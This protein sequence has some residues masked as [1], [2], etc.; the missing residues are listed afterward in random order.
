[1]QAHPDLDGWFFVGIWPL[2]AERGSMPLWEEAARNGMKTVAFDTLPVQ[3]GYLKDGLIY[4]L[5]GQKYW[6]WGL[7]PPK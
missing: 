4:A 3:L 6:G 7:I 5:V 2:F 1:M